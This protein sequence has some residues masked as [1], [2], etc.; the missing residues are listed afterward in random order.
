MFGEE[1]CVADAAGATAGGA[2]ETDEPGERAYASARPAA[3][4]NHAGWHGTHSIEED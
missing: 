4:P 1:D 2:V 3:K